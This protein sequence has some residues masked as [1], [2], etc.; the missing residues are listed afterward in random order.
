MGR[1][2]VRS[3][4]LVTGVLG[5]GG[6]RSGLDGAGDPRG[7]QIVVEQPPQRTCTLGALMSGAAV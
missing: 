2:I 6:R 4:A 3:W 7:P 5:V 1:L